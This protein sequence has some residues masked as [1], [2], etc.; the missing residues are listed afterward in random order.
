MSFSPDLHLLEQ[1]PVSRLGEGPCWDT[2]TDILYWV[3]ITGQAIHRYHP[4]DSRVET[5]KTP[6][7]VGFAVTCADGGL[8]AGLCDGIYKVD[9]ATGNF[10]KITMPEG[11]SPE[12]RFND[13]KCDRR[14]RLWCGTMNLRADDV[15]PTGELFR[16]EKGG[17]VT[18]EKDIFISNGLGWSPDNRTM[19]YTDTV[20]RVIWQYDYDLSTGEAVNRRV[21]LQ[22]NDGPGRPDGLCVDSQG[23]VLTALWPGWGVEIY[24]PDGKLDQ[25]IELPVPQISSC[26]FGGPDLKTLFI[27]T[28]REGMDLQK[29]QEAP[30]SGGVFAVEMNIPGLPEVPCEI[31]RA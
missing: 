23:R 8:I 14:G 30:L 29:L 13:G 3:D 21:F 6:S 24:T 5:C 26:A 11:M 2:A 1:L 25:R 27:T 16:M 28:A 9:F 7:M 15:P 4:V 12:N 31:D 20:R 19:Y 22:K 10:T 18:V 17:L